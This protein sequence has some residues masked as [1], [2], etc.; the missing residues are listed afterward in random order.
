MSGV[1]HL[2]NPLPQSGWAPH[3]LHP[4]PPTHEPAWQAANND[5]AMAAIGAR[6]AAFTW[7][8]IERDPG[9]ESAWSYLRGYVS[10]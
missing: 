8:H 1:L 10:K 4:A 9:N 2:D 3:S 7:A 5:E 6:E